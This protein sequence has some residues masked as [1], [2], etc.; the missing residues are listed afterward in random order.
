MVINIFLMDMEF[1]KTIYKLMVNV[2]FNNSAAKEH[3]TEIEQTICTMKEKTD[4]L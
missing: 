2:I 3:V 4:A 1:D